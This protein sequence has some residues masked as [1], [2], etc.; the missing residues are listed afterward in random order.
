MSANPAFSHSE[1]NHADLSQRV[2]ELALAGDTES[3]EWHCLDREVQRRLGD[4]YGR[5]DGDG[6]VG[7]FRPVLVSSTD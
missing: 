7:R 6:A 3:F 2:V 1:L 5:T 4:D